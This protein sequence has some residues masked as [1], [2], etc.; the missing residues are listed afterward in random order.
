MLYDVQR[1]HFWRHFC[2][3]VWWFVGHA[4]GGLQ[5]MFGWLLS[6]ILTS[7]S[8]DDVSLSFSTETTFWL[9]HGVCVWVYVCVCMFVCV[10]IHPCSGILM[11]VFAKHVHS[12]HK[13]IHIYIYIYTWSM[14]IIQRIPNSIQCHCHFTVHKD[15]K[16]HTGAATMQGP[17]SP[18]QHWDVSW[19]AGCEVRW[20]TCRKL[21]NLR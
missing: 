3:L 7:P 21:V 13:Y 17:A 8:V 9:S 16:V 10:H 14:H 6:F 4:F 1:K 18:L 12:K 11:H 2:R 19:V 15:I 20:F 5:H